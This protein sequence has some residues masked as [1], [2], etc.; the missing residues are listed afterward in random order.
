MPSA[1]A[2][3]AARQIAGASAS[4]A[5]RKV[6]FSTYTQATSSRRAASS[7]ARSSCAG[8]RVV[9]HDVDLHP[10]RADALDDATPLGAHRRRH[11]RARAARQ[12]AGH[13]RSRSPP[14]CAQSYVGCETASQLHELAD[15]ARV[16]EERLQLAVVG[17]RL[18]VVGGHELRAAHDLVDD[19]RHVVAPAPAA[20]EAER[21]AGAAC[22][23]PGGPPARGAGRPRSQRRRQ[24]EQPRE[25]QPLRDRRV[26]LVDVRRA[27][28]LQHRLLDGRRRVRD[29]RVRA[30]LAGIVAPWLAR[31]SALD[32]VDA[33][34]TV[35]GDDAR[36]A[37]ERRVELRIAGVDAQRG[38][39][40]RGELGVGRQ[41]RSGW[42]AR[43]RAGRRTRAAGC[44]GRAR[45][46]GRPPG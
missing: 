27:D 6:G 26:Q 25:A 14:P 15:Q 39:A 18:A 22:C 29:V 41:R 46:P 13:Q 20:E 9:R 33:G 36:V 38:A 21:L 4:S 40:Q 35:A 12:A 43:R 24:V 2:A 1:P 37:G 16:L 7:A 44:R 31:R 42:P 23:A 5:P 17:V 45:S 11:E 28:G 32:R 10:R 19:R 30:R 8:G 34:A 3:W